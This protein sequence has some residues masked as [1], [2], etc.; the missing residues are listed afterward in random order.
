MSDNNSDN[1][2]TN[3]PATLGDLENVQENLSDNIESSQHALSSNIAS[4]QFSLSDNISS[5]EENL[6]KLILNTCNCPPKCDLEF[7]RKETNNFSEINGEKLPGDPKPLVN[8][9]TLL[10]IINSQGQRVYV[11]KG[12]RKAGTRV[13]IH[14]HKYG[15][16]TLILSGTMTDF[17]QGKDRMTFGP[18]SG[19]YMPPCTPM[20]AANLGDEDVEL[21][22][23]F[24]GPPNE[25]YITILE[26]D[27][28]YD[29]I[30]RFDGY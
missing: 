25:E 20:S 19:Y 6:S 1:P 14:V 8:G 16:Y 9:V 13:G 27:W 26:P 24:I 17:V 21:I 5:I 10:N 29:R 4:I 11:H 3:V 30:G 18:N 22:D 28:K 7:L 15:G 12:T 23:I 2:N